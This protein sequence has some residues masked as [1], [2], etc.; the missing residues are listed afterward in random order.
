MPTKMPKARLLESDAAQKLLDNC[1][2]ML[3]KSGHR[4]KMIDH[5]SEVMKKSVL[6]ESVW[7]EVLIVDM[8]T[9]SHEIAKIMFCAGIQTIAENRKTD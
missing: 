5:F 4:Q 7:C 9:Y 8:P 6:A 2:K 1:Q 3:I